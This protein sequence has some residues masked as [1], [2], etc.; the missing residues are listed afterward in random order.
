V[1]RKPRDDIGEARP[2]DQE[3]GSLAA[4][5]IAI[6]IRAKRRSLGL[7]Q[8]ELAQRIGVSRSAIAQWETDRTGQVRANLTRMA[9]VLGVSVGYL[10][11]GEQDGT[12]LAVEA[13]DERALLNL[14]RQ[15]GEPG[16]AELLRIA[17]SLV[18]RPA[19]NQ[20]DDVSP[21]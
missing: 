19:S 18:D 16:R 11:S 8:D 7:T 3:E 1:T 13:A 21:N 5:G 6:R 15:L 10:M 9:A 14:Y 17:R 4:S 12:V 2:S 20:S